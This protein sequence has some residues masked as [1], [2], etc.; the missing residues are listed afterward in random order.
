MHIALTT[1]CPHLFLWPGFVEPDM[2][3][4]LQ[5]FVRLS[6]FLSPS[7]CEMERFPPSAFLPIALGRDSHEIIMKQQSARVGLGA[8]LSLCVVSFV[9]SPSTPASRSPA[10]FYHQVSVNWHSATRVICGVFF[11]SSTHLCGHHPVHFSPAC[12]C[13]LSRLRLASPL[14]LSQLSR[15]AFP[16]TP[17][18]FQLSLSSAFFGSA[19]SSPELVCARACPRCVARR[20]LNAGK[21]DIFCGRARA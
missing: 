20:S 1:V 3:I 9:V 12:P 17:H 21:R 4:H 6:S 18:S 13:P 16:S 10:L 5:L 11:S 15:A 14:I 7:R 8:E 19:F 2:Q